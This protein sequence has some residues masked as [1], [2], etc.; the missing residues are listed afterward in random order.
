[1]DEPTA[2]CDDDAAAVRRVLDGDVDAFETIVVR[3]QGPL[4]SLAYRY[5]HNRAIAEE[6]AQEAFLKIYQA[7]QGWRREARFSSWMFAVAHNHYR[8]ALRRRQ[9]PSLSIEQIARSVQGG[10]LGA[11]L[12]A[13]WRNEAIRLA[14]STL[15]PKYREVIVLY[16]FHQMD[17]AETARTAR[18]REGTVKARLF[19]ARKLLERK[20]A[21]L[22]AG[23]M[24]SPTEA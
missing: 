21:V 4:V 17:L 5:C 16:Y 8:S 9:P 23:T 18:L 13:G 1:M 24:L 6:L 19:R 12:D 7:L 20:L 11:E 10:D 15:P 2:N 22:S 14:V 3:W